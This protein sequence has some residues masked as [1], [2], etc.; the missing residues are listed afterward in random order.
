MPDTALVSPN[1]LRY[2]SKS[3]ISCSSPVYNLLHAVVCSSPAYKSYVH[4]PP[5][6]LLPFHCSSKTYSA[7]NLHMLFTF[8]LIVHMQHM[9]SQNNHIH[10]N[11]I[12]FLERMRFKIDD[13]ENGSH[14]KFCR[15]FHC[16]ISTSVPNPKSADGL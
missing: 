16:A 7:I 15:T 4:F 12:D 6:T 2:M 14:C 11:S 8:V 9:Y 10:I 3:C 1:T 5:T 13:V